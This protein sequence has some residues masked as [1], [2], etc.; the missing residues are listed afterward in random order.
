VL[1]VS[2]GLVHFGFEKWFFGNICDR[3]LVHYLML[4]RKIKRDGLDHGLF[5]NY[6]VDKEPRRL[7]RIARDFVVFKELLLALT[8]LV[9]S[10]KV[11]NGL[12]KICRFIQN[13]P[14]FR[15][16]PAY[17][18]LSSHLVNWLDSVAVRN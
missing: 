5:L 2:D 6:L 7:Q 12:S 11:R 16:V 4:A 14:R 9:H 18:M 13:S 3:D 1:E 17:Q 8:H 10:K 15:R